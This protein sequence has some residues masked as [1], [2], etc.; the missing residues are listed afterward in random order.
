MDL[1][2][3]LHVFRMLVGEELGS[4]WPC[5][6]NDGSLLCATIKVIYDLVLTGI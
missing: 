1:E 4:N 6:F 5:Y 2:S 3:S